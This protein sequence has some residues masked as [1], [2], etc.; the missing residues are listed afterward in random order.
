MARFLESSISTKSSRLTRRPSDARRVRI[1]QTYSGVFAPIRELFA[2]LPESRERGYKPGR[3]S[4][5]VKGGRCEACQGD[6]LRRIEMNF[7]PD[8][9]VMC[10]VCR[11]RR[12]NSETLAVRFKGHSISDILNMQAVDALKLLENHSANSAEA[13]HHRGSRTRLRAARPVCHDLVGR[14]SAED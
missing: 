13:C 8:V 7:L 3:F 12:Y 5:N 9:Y 10:E 6:G 2:M 1:P 14:R 11:G 4:F